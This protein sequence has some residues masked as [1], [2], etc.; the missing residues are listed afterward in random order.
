MKSN[1]QT[2]HVQTVLVVDDDPEWLNFLSR[3][4]GSQ[5][6]VLSAA[7]GEADGSTTAMVCPD[8]EGCEAL[9]IK[10]SCMDVILRNK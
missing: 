4:I 10:L 8:D 6:P 2:V 3:T 5:Y 9:A 1:A 7:N